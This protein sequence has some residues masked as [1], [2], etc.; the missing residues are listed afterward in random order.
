LL[1]W[2]LSSGRQGPDESEL[3]QGEDE[4]DLVMT[5][6]EA[7]PIA[8]EFLAIEPAP[9]RGSRL[10]TTTSTETTPGLPPRAPD[11]HPIHTQQPSRD[12]WAEPAAKPDPNR[13]PDSLLR[14]RGQGKPT[15]GEGEGTQRG[16]RWQA[17]I[18]AAAAHAGTGEADGRRTDLLAAEAG[19]KRGYPT[20]W[21]DSGEGTMRATGEPFG[22]KIERDGSI[23]F[24]D[25]PNV[26]IDGLSGR[27]DLTDAVMSSLGQTLYPHRKLK[28]MDDSRA[29]RAEMSRRRRQES[30]KEAIASYPKMLNQIWRD[31]SYS[32][33]QRK[34]LLFALWDECAEEGPESVVSTARAIR[35]STTAFIRRKLPAGSQWAYSAAELAALN[36]RRQSAAPFAPYSP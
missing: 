7:E 3:E 35:A 20:P 33:A 6:V 19:T 1:L 32:P 9:K 16:S 15:T 22:A 13:S 26:Q 2:L 4:A 21:R 29:M 36:Q 11:T 12:E 17:T 30:L 34:E 18:D 24:R 23:H 10:A 28:L 14:M 8:I 25:E 27:F 31:P 5:L